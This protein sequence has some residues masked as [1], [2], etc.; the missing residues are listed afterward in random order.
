MA[1]LPLRLFTGSVRQARPVGS[2]ETA[3]S[4]RFAV[5]DPDFGELVPGNARYGPLPFTVIAAANWRSLFEAPTE[6]AEGEVPG[7]DIV[8]G[9]GPVFP[10]ETT[11]R[12][13]A[14]VAFSNA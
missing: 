13:P 10:A 12:T 8:F 9:S 1:M 2:S 6:I 14:A 3:M 5:I 7:L 4:T 11:T